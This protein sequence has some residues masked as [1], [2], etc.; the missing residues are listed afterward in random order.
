MQK[1]LKEVISTVNVNGIQI[2]YFEDGA[3]WRYSTL[4]QKEPETIEW[5]DT[6]KPEETMWDIGANVGIYSV[7]AALKGVKTYAFEP[8]FAN[9]YQLCKSIAINKLQD[10]VI[11]LCVAF[12]DM[13]SVSYINLASTEIGTSMSNFKEAIDFRGRPFVPAFL[14]GMIAYDIDNFIKEFNIKIPNHI[15]IDVDGIEL[16]IVKG[17]QSTFANKTLK[18]LSIELIETDQEQVEQVTKILQESGLHFIHKKQNKEF[19]TKDTKD[20]LNYLFHRN[21]EEY[22][23]LSN[24]ANQIKEDGFSKKELIDKIVNS[25]LLATTE[26]EP[27]EN[28][29][30][31]DILPIGIYTEMLSNLP[32]IESMNP[33]DHPDAIKNDGE[34]TRFL[35]DLTTNSISK[36]SEEKKAFWNKM[37]EIFIAEDIQKAILTKFG[38]TIKERFGNEIPEIVTVPIYYRDLPG[39]KIGIHPDAESKIATLQFYLPESEDQRHLGTTFHRKIKNNFEKIKTNEFIPNSAYAFVRTN[40]SWHSVEQIGEHEK[41][42]NSIALTFYIKGKEYKSEKKDTVYYDDSISDDLKLVVSKFTR[43]DHVANLF[44]QDS[45]GVELGVAAGDFSSRLLNYPNVSYLFSIDMWAGDRGHGIDQYREAIAALDKFRDRNTIMRMKF[46]EALPLFNNESL[47]FIYVDG[48]AHDGE[49]N[50]KTFNDWYPKL[51]RGGI[52]AGDDYSN[53]WPLVVEAVNIFAKNN[54]LELHIIDC[55]EDTWNSKYPTWLAIKP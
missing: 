38:K 37:R 53:D 49:Q 5:I 47:D 39:Y 35:L 48:Y 40:E 19:A 13:K 17:A 36:L 50:G 29:Y 7:Y 16:A 55:H 4:A 25:I 41:H 31:K 33:I 2:N 20:V 21:P 23:M 42:R 46:D 43:R 6:F 52:I 26:V 54:N 45:I 15:K 10:S 51:K 12:S 44:R 22:Y 27:C 11:P 1:N 18:S 34:C 9:Y 8:H 28:I 32:D 30:I 14:Q 24:K 3:G